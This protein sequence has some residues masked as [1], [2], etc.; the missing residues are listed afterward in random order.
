MPEVDPRWWTR[1]PAFLRRPQCPRTP[2]TADRSQRDPC[3][4]FS[5]VGDDHKS[6]NPGD[7]PDFIS[8]EGYLNGVGGP[9]D[10]GPRPLG[11]LVPGLKGSPTPVFVPKTSTPLEADDSD[12]AMPSFALWSMRYLQHGHLFGKAESVI[13]ESYG[14][15]DHVVY[16]MDDGRKHCLISRLVGTSPDG[17]A[18]PLVGHIT[19]EAYERL[20]DDHTLT[21]RIFREAERLCLCAVFEAREAVSNVSV[22]RSFSSI[23]EVPPEYLPPSPALKFTDVPDGEE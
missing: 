10:L 23:D 1:V 2:R 11:G 15:D 18:Y 16:V 3:I 8:E 9:L 20:V 7:D 12:D 17:C 6:S 19:V 5:A 21:D 22:V 4:Q 13:R 14:R